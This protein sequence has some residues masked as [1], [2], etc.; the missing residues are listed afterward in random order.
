MTSENQS[1]EVKND[2]AEEI[3]DKYYPKERTFF[4]E[5]ILKAMEEYQTEALEGCMESIKAYVDS[6]DLQQ[7]PNSNYR[8]GKVFGLEAAMLIVKNYG[9]PS[10]RSLAVPRIS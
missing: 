5:Q 7:T 1:Q 9:A 6:I 4:R 10:D 3:L 2:R 8:V